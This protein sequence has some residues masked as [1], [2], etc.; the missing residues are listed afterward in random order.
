MFTVGFK[1]VD[2]QKCTK[3]KLCVTTIC[4]SGAIKLT[5]ENWPKFIEIYCVGCNGCVNLCPTD[6]IWTY[7]T[8][9]KKQYNLYKEFILKEIPKNKLT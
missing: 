5:K 6:A 9:N 1:R 4:P 3:C 7:Q 8:R 2:K